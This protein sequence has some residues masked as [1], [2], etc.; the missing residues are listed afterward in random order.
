MKKKTREKVFCFWDNC[1]SPGIVKL[2]LL[3]TGYISLA[4]NMLANSPKI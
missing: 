2:I 4:A 3:R 1:I